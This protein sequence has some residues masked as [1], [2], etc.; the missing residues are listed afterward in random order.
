[1]AHE[2][3]WKDDQLAGRTYDTLPVGTLLVRYDFENT[4]GVLPWLVEIV[5]V[6]VDGKSLM[7]LVACFDRQEWAIQWA[8]S[9][10][11]TVLGQST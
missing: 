10:D 11:V 3:I 6:V 4:Y 9:L 8:Q 5:R 7:D 2:V 1:M